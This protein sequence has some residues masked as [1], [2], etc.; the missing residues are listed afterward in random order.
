MPYCIIRPGFVKACCVNWGEKSDEFRG[1]QVVL[2]EVYLSANRTVE[3]VPRPQIHVIFGG[4][5]LVQDAR[6]LF[7]RRI[8]SKIAAKRADRVF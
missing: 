6:L 4:R 2:I 7:G 8:Q 1:G 3:V 5:R